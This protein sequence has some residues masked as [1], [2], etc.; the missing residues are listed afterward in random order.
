MKKVYFVLML[1][2]F[3]LSVP[4]SASAESVN[5]NQEGDLYY[6]PGDMRSMIRCGTFGISDSS[7]NEDG[8]YHHG[9]QNIGY[10]DSRTGVMVV[11][12]T[13]S[14]EGTTY[15]AGTY[16]IDD[17]SLTFQYPPGGNPA[18]K[19]MWGKTYSYGGALEALADCTGNSIYTEQL[20]VYEELIATPAPTSAPTSAPSQQGTSSGD[21]VQ[22]VADRMVSMMKTVGNRAVSLIVT[23][24]PFIIGLT[25]VVIILKAGLRLIKKVRG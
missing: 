24:A 10:Y 12:Y 11:T 14:H 1:A 23:A 2:V 7:W 19:E 3:C 13:G 20:T 15:T 21:L 25:A 22:A 6:L 5:R 18:M 9:S 17:G 16:S 4:A 8:I